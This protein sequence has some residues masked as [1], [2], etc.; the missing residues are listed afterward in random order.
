MEQVKAAFEAQLEKALSDQRQLAAM[1]QSLRSELAE[2]QQQVGQ[3]SVAAINSLEDSPSVQFKE[4]EALLDRTGAS[5]Q[6]ATVDGAAL[7]DFD[8]NLED[9]VP[10]AAGP[11]T[12]PFGRSG[13]HGINVVSRDE[14]LMSASNQVQRAQE[15]DHKKLKDERKYRNRRPGGWKAEKG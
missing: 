6:L 14:T 7:P 9:H 15:V 12:L 5:L 3:T 8:G 4:D 13:S 2:Q 11:L 10:L 1:V